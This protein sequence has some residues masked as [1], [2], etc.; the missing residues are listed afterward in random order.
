MR[1]GRTEE[2]PNSNRRT[3]WLETK[4]TRIGAQNADY[5]ND[6]IYCAVQPPVD[7]PEATRSD[8]FIEDGLGLNVSRGRSKSVAKMAYFSDTLE[9]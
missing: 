5:A 8:R 6:L 3:G 9:R 4:R 2:E 7:C 1:L